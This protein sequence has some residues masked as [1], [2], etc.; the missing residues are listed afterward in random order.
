MA[1]NTNQNLN[2]E[3]KIGPKKNDSGCL[4]KIGLFFS[5]ILTHFSYPVLF[6]PI[7]M[8]R[9]VFSTG[10]MGALAPAML[11][12]GYEHPQFLDNLVK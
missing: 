10:A 11:K 1:I 6:I 2:F 4:S 5:S 8:V 7:A 12:K 9:G 3:N